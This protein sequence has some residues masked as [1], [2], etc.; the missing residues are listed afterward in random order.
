MSVPDPAPHS[1][2]YTLRSA[3][4]ESDDNSMLNFFEQ[5]SNRVPQ[6]LQP[7]TFPPTAQGFQSLHVLSNTCF[8][9]FCRGH[10]NWCEVVSHFSFDLHFLHE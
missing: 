10:P 9:V 1:F 5:P 8:L 4:A 7:V 3:V 6:W 2:G